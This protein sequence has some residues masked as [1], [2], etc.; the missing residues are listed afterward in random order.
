MLSLMS[1]GEL[2]ARAA[3]GSILRLLVHRGFAEVRDNVVTILT[4]AAEDP[5]ALDAERAEKSAQ[6]ARERLRSRDAD[7]DHCRAEAA[8]ER[9]LARLRTS[10]AMRS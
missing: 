7:I 1:S 10:S 8:L 6:R 9:A 3:D 4:D 5:D 2:R